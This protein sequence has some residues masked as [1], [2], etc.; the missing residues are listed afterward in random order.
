M[1]KEESKLIVLGINH[2]TS[3]V[4]MR[5]KYQI[6]RKE[7]T[8]ALKYLNSLND[9]DG[10]VIISTCNRVEFYLVI[11]PDTDP[12]LIIND[13]YCKHKKIDPSMN[14]SSFYL[15]NE[16]KA[17]EHLFKVAS[18]LDSMLIGEYQVLNQI[19][20]AYSIACSE[21]TTGKILHKLFHNA[22]RVSKA[23][24]TKTRIGSCNQSLSGVAFKIIK[25]KLKKEDV[26]TII[27]VNQNTKIIAE[28]LSNAGYSHLLFVNRT[29]HKAEELADKYKGVAFSLD[30]IEEPLFSSKCVFSCT[31][32][33]GYIINPDLINEI[34]LKNGL[35][36]L[37]IDMAVPRDI[38]TM[39]LTNDIEVIDLE[40]LKKYLEA[41]KKESALDLPE[42]EKIISSEANIFEAWNESQTDD[43]SC[44][45]QEKIEA[46]RLQ[47]LDEIRLQISE[48]EI[49]LL[50][51]FSHSLVHRMKSLITQAIKTT[52]VDT[53]LNKGSI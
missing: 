28:K 33:S 50:D 37:V 40:G 45:I 5:E 38:N 12:F 3:N 49:E 39:G 26:I 18:G 31:G 1:S 41:E 46:V 19:K 21:K 27:G 32:A 16:V 15:Y 35:P 53:E 24:R 36:Q 7:M 52:P 43:C 30:Y 29:L 22:F 34:Y 10:V 2:K 42:A 48:D 6:N 47:L 13:F 17:V 51:R 25:E 14:R 8:S 9:V 20:D 11:K 23:V 4:S 44:L